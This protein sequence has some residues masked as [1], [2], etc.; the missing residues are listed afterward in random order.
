MSETE[1]KLLMPQA[2]WETFDP[3]A[4]L[5]TEEEPAPD[6]KVFVYTALDAPDGKVRVQLEA[7]LAEESGRAPTVLIIQE[8]HRSPDPFLV[9]AIYAAGYNVVVPDFSKVAKDTK[10]SFPESYAYGEYRLAGDHLKRV[11]PSAKETS[12]YLYS[13]IV[14]RA[15]TLI[16]RHISDGKLILVG[17]GDAVEVAMQVE[18]SGAGADALA[19]LNGSGYREYIKHNRYGSSDELEIDEERMCWLTGVASVAYAKYIRC[20]V[21]IAVGSNAH[22][23]DIDRLQSLKAL[24]ASQ[25]VHIVISPRA[26][27]FMLPEAF[28]SLLIWLNSVAKDTVLD[29]PEMPD[30]DIRI[31]E[32]GVVYFDLDCDP[33]SMIKRVQIFYASGEYSHE[34]R[35]WKDLRGISVSYNEYIAQAEE[36]DPKAPVFA[37]GEVEY[38][39]GFVISSLVAYMELA[40]QPVKGGREEKSAGGMVV[41][42]PCDDESG[43]VEDFDGSVLPEGG[44]RKVVT[45]GGISGLTSDSGGLRTY[46]FRPVGAD[47]EKFLKI[48]FYTEKDENAVVALISVAD[49]VKKYVATRRIADTKGMFSGQQFNLSDFKEEFSHRTLSDWDGV[50]ALTIHG[51]NIVVGNILFI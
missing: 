16:K 49:G 45:A 33:A 47:P 48:E 29:L 17:L 34:V 24:T 21:F 2:I 25:S 28:N 38:E 43:F 30:L 46:R 1:Y 7:K 51:N 23:C 4:P 40:G 8:Y 11:M 41:Y 5:E 32:D 19:C 26:G 15:I 3:N 13:V 44:I 20:P 27:D 14:K 50:K 22:Q 6:G 42:D 31:N 10:T 9:D 37:F 12:Q 18:G 36:Y 39:N 35:D